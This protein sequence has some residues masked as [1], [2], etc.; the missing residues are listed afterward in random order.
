[1]TP[2][3]KTGNVRHLRPVL[4]LIDIEDARARTPLDLMLKARSRTQ[5]KL[6]VCTG[7]KLE[8]AVDEPKR[9]PCSGRRMIRTEVL[10]AVG[11]WATHDLESRP[12]LLGVEPQR[13]KL[14]V[15]AKLEVVL[16]LVRLDELVLEERSLL[17]GVRDEGFDVHELAL[18][19]T[20]EGTGIARARL[21][22]ASNA[23]PKAP[24]FADVQHL[25]AGAS[26]DVNA[27]RCRK[28]VEL[29]SCR[30]C[31][32]ARSIPPLESHAHR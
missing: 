13:Q 15:V 4:L 14:L 16:G 25:P 10:S 2:V 3:E 21:E 17:V 12:W 1:V 20:H 32:H 19:S 11:F 6:G 31:N 7:P 26:E 23:A 24:R 30:V 5:P 8:I 27:R 29:S 28:I 9:L 22:V 18:E